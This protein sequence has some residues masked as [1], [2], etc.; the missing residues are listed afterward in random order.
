MLENVFKANK[1]ISIYNFKPKFQKA[2]QPILKWLHSINVSAN[3]ITITSIILSLAIGICFWLSDDYK[4]L[5]LVLPIGLLLRMALNALDGMMARQFNQQSKLG[6][7]LN[8]VGDILSDIF[9]FFPLLKFESGHIYIIV[10]FLVL[11]IINEFSGVMGKVIGNERRYEGPMGK[12][13]RA[14]FISLY[15]ILS[16]FDSSLLKYSNWLFL[17]VI[18]LLI[19]STFTRLKK[20]INERPS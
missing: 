14:L 15:G 5:F 2:L 18:G 19:M 4:V 13:D 11:T 16:F 8:E 9:I 10:V 7:L 3:Q 1:M 12:S 6:E 17:F 20:A